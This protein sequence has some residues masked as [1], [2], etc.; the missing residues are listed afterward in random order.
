MT[1]TGGRLARP[2]SS[3]WTAWPTRSTCLRTT[4]KSCV[5]PS[6]DTSRTPVAPVA[7]ARPQ[8]GRRVVAVGGGAPPVTAPTGGASVSP[9]LDTFCLFRLTYKQGE[10]CLN[11]RRYPRRGRGATHRD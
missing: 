1:S 6:R 9:P 8:L 2:S 3:V 7:V 11:Q 4:R 10:G 5:T